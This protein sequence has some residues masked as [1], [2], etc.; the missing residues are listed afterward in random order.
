MISRYEDYLSEPKA[1]TV[2]EMRSIH[3][4]MISEIG[5]DADG[6]ELYDELMMIAIRYA[7]IRLAGH[8]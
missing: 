6:L 2:E 1:L 5:C 4:A 7:S 8:C 3:E